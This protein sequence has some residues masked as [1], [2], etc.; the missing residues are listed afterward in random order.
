[1]LPSMIFLVSQISHIMLTAS[2]ATETRKNV[3]LVGYGPED[4]YLKIT[5]FFVPDF[6]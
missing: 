4:D 3:K 6:I 5:F 1:M 2:E